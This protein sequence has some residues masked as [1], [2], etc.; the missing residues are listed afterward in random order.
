[1]D[2]VVSEQFLAKT[3]ISIQQKHL[4]VSKSALIIYS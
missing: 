3:I 4:L 1:M 2:G